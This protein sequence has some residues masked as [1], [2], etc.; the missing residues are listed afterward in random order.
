MSERARDDRRDEPRRRDEAPARAPEPPA[1]GAELD[2]AAILPRQRGSGNA[3]ISRYL[4]Q[5]VVARQDSDSEE[6]DDEGGGT[7]TAEHDPEALGRE[8]GEALM[9]VQ[10]AMGGALD[11]EM[12]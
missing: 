10:E 8:M 1:A 12:T 9:T 4:G 2:S 11:P 6:S 5:R 3:A 7:A